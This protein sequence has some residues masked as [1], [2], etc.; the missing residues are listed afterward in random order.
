MPILTLKDVD[1]NLIGESLKNYVSE[2]EICRVYDPCIERGSR[3]AHP[4]TFVLKPAFWVVGICTI[5]QKVE[6]NETESNMLG[7]QVIECLKLVL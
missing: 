6:S 7:L 4:G 2:S 1:P 5:M 3:L